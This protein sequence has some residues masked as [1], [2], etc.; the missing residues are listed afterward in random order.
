MNYDSVIF[1]IDGTLWNA[2]PASAEGW[3]RGLASLGLDMEV[4]AADIESVA[5]KPYADCV[6]TLFPG[7]A[8]KHEQVIQALEEFEMRA[9]KERGGKFFPGVLE[10]IPLL[11]KKYKVF[12]VSNCQEWYM[13][14]FL[15][16]SGLEPVLS[17]YDCHGM[18]GMP[19][20]E[21]I[22]RLRRTQSLEFPVY[23]GDTAGDEKASRYAGADYVHMAYGFGEAENPLRAFD[24][25]DELT[26]WL[27]ALI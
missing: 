22:L 24:E 23:V 7:L 27:L 19:K 21:T 5:G 4:S 1:D 8:S 20:G 6:E 2:S 15:E 16:K 12:L 10:G 14:L 9:V 17:G 13:N 25:F 3:S 26:M 11:A 18:S